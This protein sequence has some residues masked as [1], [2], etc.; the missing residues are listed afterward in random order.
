MR[1]LELEPRATRKEVA[2]PLQVFLRDRFS[3]NPRI[4]QR[5]RERD[6]FRNPLGIK[7]SV[8]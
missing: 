3:G 1:E 6:P 7:V 2:Q 5:Q 8:G 4:E